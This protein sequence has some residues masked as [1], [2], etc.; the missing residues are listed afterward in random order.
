VHTPASSYRLAVD[1]DDGILTVTACQ[2]D[3]YRIHL[4]QGLT[5]GAFSDHLRALAEQLEVSQIV[6]AVDTVAA[7]HHLGVIGAAVTRTG[8][9]LCVIPVR[10]AEVGNSPDGLGSLIRALQQHRPLLLGVGGGT[11]CAMVRTTV[12]RHLPG[13][14]YALVPTTVRAQI[15]AG[16]GGNAG[17]NDGA[18]DQLHGAYHHPAG[19]Y[20]DPALT[21]TLPS[22]DVR[23]GLAEAIKVA[24]ITNPLLL[25]TLERSAGPLPAGPVLAAIVDQAVASRLMLLALDP[26][27][28]RLLR[29]GHLVADPYR[30]ATGYRIPQG[31]AVAAGMAVAAAHAF[32]S[33]KT[34]LEHRDRILHLLAAYQ[35]PVTI[36]DAKRQPVWE[37]MAAGQHTRHGS[38]S[39][40]I[41]HR[42][43]L[44]TLADDFDRSAF[45]KAL[46]DLAARP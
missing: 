16:T 13:V 19:V 23:A 41:P 39:L 46:D 34:T 30:A 33:G 10:A 27:M 15:H 12:A 43:G 38:L 21:S 37:A 17:A 22:R 36:P 29:L 9:P 31:E 18:P 26:K 11:V 28:R 40:V 5:T 24:L 35:L 25:N 4:A 44:C 8:L 14:P 20:I 45:D 42:P 7:E 2:T 32:L 3:T 6:L 1:A